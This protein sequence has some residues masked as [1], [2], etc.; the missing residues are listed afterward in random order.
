MKKITLWTAGLVLVLAAPAAAT[1]RPG[2]TPG[3]SGNLTAVAT[4]QTVVFGA[5]TVVAG[6]LSGNNSGAQQVTLTE[7]PFP[8][9]GGYINPLTVNTDANGNYSFRDVPESNRNYQ[10]TV[11]GEKAFTGVRVRMRV[12]LAA[13]DLTPARGQRVRFSGSVAPKHDGRQALI[14]RR[15]ATGVWVTV[16]RPTL[17]AVTTGNRSTYSTTMAILRSGS[18]RARVLAH[19]DHVT[20]TSVTRVLRV[21]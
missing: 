5:A 14:Q 19:G 8:Y 20:G 4:P 6:K 3:G 12:S 2:H 9:G 18:Y 21:H 7:D 1:H 13:S 10:V 15:S 17:R 11:R 16:R